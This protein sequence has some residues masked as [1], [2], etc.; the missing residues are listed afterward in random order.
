[1]SKSLIRKNQL[2]PDI[3]DLVAQYGSGLF[4]TSGDLANYQFTAE[5]T[6]TNVVY[7]TGDQT[8]SGVKSF[9]SRPTVNGT[10]VLLSGEAA[11]L[12]NTIVYTTGDQTISGSKN[13]LSRPTFNSTG[14]L[15]PS[16]LENIAIQISGLVEISGDVVF[17]TGDQTIDG[18]KNFTTRPTVNGTGVLLSGESAQ[19]P[20][21]IVYTTGNQTISGPK[22]VKSL[23]IGPPESSLNETIDISYYNNNFRSVS[24]TRMNSSIIYN[25]LIKGS[26]SGLFNNSEFP[27][28]RSIVPGN[29]TFWGWIFN[30][31]AVDKGVLQ[32][33]NT[34]GYLNI[35]GPPENF[36]Y[37]DISV[38]GSGYNEYFRLDSQSGVMRLTRRPTVNG[39]GVLLSGEA[40]QLP[41]TI[42][43]TTGD[44][45]ISGNKTF[46][47]QRYVFSGANVIFVD[48]TGIV[49]GSWEFN[50]RPTVNGTGVLLSGEA[51][52]S[53]LP[54]T[55]VYTTGNQTISGSKIFIN[56]RSWE[57]GLL[58]GFNNYFIPYSGGNFDGKPQ[59][60]VTVEV[61]GNNIY[62]FNIQNRSI[63]GFNIN[64]SN[65]IL[66]SG[67][68]LNVQAKL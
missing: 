61:T 18:L 51:A 44:Q 39:T 43:Y 32:L 7:T 66:E 54:D 40:A 14:L 25:I 60:Q 22:T 10:G 58:P 6:G 28:G 55:I 36:K 48:N 11:Q 1:M 23:R 19:L 68:I 42:V 65:P 59:V 2:H 26:G 38:V 49:S 31:Q 52:Q 30:G 34:D 27:D 3:A 4:V 17:A 63:S 8:I 29:D 16:D 62:L 37:F 53:Q 12:P 56:D 45:T 47:A 67:V 35:F 5:L 15:I 64:F 9:T 50:S 13:F 41:N 20:E 57:T 21:T 33:N 24:N 46:S